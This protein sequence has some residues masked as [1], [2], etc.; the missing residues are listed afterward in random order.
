MNEVIL[1]LDCDGVILNT[2]DE[3]YSMMKER[4]LDITNWRTVNKFFV[5]IDWN[6]LIERAGVINDAINK[7][8]VINELNLFKEVVILTKTSGNLYEEGIKRKFFGEVLPSIRVITVDFNA[9][10]DEVVDPVNNILVEDS[11]N[12]AT[13]WNNAGGIGILFVKEKQ[14]YENDIIDDLS[15]LIKTNGV[16]KLLRTRNIQSFML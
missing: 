2:I 13:R 5:D 6:M 3:A 4:G 15:D 10:K 8:K 1:Y 7:I 12:N 14:D 16:K 9:N 11:V